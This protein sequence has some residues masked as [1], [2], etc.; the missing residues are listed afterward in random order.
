MPRV[1][2]SGKSADPSFHQESPLLKHRSDAKDDF[3]NK[4]GVGVF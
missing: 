1:A 2:N 4:R 3:K